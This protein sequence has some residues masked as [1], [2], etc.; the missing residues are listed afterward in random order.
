MPRKERYLTSLAWTVEASREALTIPPFLEVGR[1]RKPE[2][3]WSRLEL[4]SSTKNWSFLTG[5]IAGLAVCLTAKA[6][7]VFPLR[8]LPTRWWK[9]RLEPSGCF[10]TSIILVLP[11]SDALSQ[12]RNRG[13]KR[14]DPEH[15]CVVPKVKCRHLTEVALRGTRAP[16][17]CQRRQRWLASEIPW[18]VTAPIE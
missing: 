18:P 8:V 3:R 10:N 12:R 13:R 6:L 11:R 7:E 14:Q 5:Q 1:K 4:Q 17:T 2:E 16:Y 9:R 15:K